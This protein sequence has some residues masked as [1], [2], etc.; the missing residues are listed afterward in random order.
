LAP[1]RQGRR[2]LGV[3]GGVPRAVLLGG[4]AQAAEANAA[5]ELR[6]VQ[7]SDSDSYN[8]TYAIVGTY[9]YARSSC[10]DQ[11]GTCARI[12]PA[13]GPAGDGCAAMNLV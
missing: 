2:G 11:A 13:R 10:D 7:V 9:P 12:D 1:E 8:L 4:S 5:S 3:S 6:F